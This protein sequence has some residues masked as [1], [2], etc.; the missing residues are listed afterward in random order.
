MIGLMPNVDNAPETLLFDRKAQFPP[1]R[2]QRTNDSSPIL[3]ERLLVGVLT[4][5]P[6]GAPSGEALLRSGVCFGPSTPLEL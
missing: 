3:V 2:T 6:S 4:Y 5:A 1:V